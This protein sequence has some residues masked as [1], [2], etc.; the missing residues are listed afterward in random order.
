MNKFIEIANEKSDNDLLSIVYEFDQWSPEMLE[1]VESELSKREI[2]PT[3]IN[4]RRQELIEIEDMELSKGKEASVLWL[5]VG[6][7]TVFGFL[8]IYI[9]YNFSYSKIKSK[10]TNISYFE[11]NE[12][13]R[14]YGSYLFNTSLLCLLLGI[15]YTV[16]KIN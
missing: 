1:A 4:T 6:W 14:E 7:L 9:G 8:G 12:K 11:Y 13:S 15:I 3:D 2:L 5:I 16:I 10:Y